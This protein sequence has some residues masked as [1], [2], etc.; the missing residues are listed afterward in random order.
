[1]TQESLQLQNKK[2]A[3]LNRL[4]EIAEQRKMIDAM[5]EKTYSSKM[6]VFGIFSEEK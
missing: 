6:P 4:Q 2:I 5:T 3:I 1:M